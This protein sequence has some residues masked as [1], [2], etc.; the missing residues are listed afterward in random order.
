MTTVSI[1]EREAV[2]VFRVYVPPAAL[3]LLTLEADV[4]H[5]PLGDVEGEDFRFC[6]AAQSKGPYCAVHAQLARRGR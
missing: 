2:R 6:L 4:C 5:W 3:A 1:R